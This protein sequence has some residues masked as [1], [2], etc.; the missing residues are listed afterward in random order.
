MK[1]I[2]TRDALC[3][4]IDAEYVW[5]Y[6]EIIILKDILYKNKMKPKVESSLA[7]ALVILSYSHWEGFVK[8][9]ASYFFSYLS[10][11]A[12]SRDQMAPEMLASC[13]QHLCDNRKAADAINEILRCLNNPKY[14]FNYVESILTSAESNLNYDVLLKISTNM[15]LDIS[16]LDTKRARLDM[17]VLGRRN[18]MAH[19]EKTNVDYDYGIEV[20]NAVIEFMQDYKTLLLNMISEERY[21]VRV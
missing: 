16:S 11:I 1:K 21:K 7:R 15:G 10:F 20:S 2:K 8:Y 19:G 14:K 6:R 3:D 5:R 17:V 12:L 13:I 18:D 4:I 9:A